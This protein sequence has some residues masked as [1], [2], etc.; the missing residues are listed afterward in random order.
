MKDVS[1]LENPSVQTTVNLP[2]PLYLKI[3]KVA[4]NEGVSFAEIVRRLVK[5]EFEKGEPEQGTT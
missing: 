4:Q 1:Y 2:F 5:K 3:V